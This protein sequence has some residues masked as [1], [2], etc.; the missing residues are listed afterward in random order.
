[1]QAIKKEMR[2]LQNQATAL[3]LGRT[4]GNEPM[5]SSFGLALEYPQ[6]ENV[7]FGDVMA[8]RVKRPIMGPDPQRLLRY[9]RIDQVQSA[10]E[11]EQVAQAAAK[12][13]ERRIDPGRNEFFSSKPAPVAVDYPEP[14]FY[15][16][17]RSTTV[18]ELKT[19]LFTSP[20][21]GVIAKFKALNPGLSQV[22]AG[23][24]IVLSDPENYRCTQEEAQLMA[25][26]SVV[27]EALADLSPEEADFMVRHRDEIESFITYGSTGTSI[28]AAM[29]ESNL[30]NVKGVLEAIED[31]HTRSFAKHGHLRSPE[32]FAER[33]K[34]FAQLDTHL[35][36]LT[37][38]TID[39]PDHPKQNAALGISSRGLVHRWSW[40]GGQGMSPGYATHIDKVTKA[41][42]Y[43]KYGGWIGTAVGGGVS[44]MKVQDVCQA[45]DAEACEKAKYT[46]TGGLIGGVTGGILAGG[47]LS[48]VGT[49]AICA[50]LFVP[51][52][53]IGTLACG[54]VVAGG[55]TFGT[56]YVL[57]MAGEKAGERIYE[58]N[59]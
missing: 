45:G 54:L 23:Q 41:S 14:G 55:V 30:N 22:K 38:I 42:K 50:A 37:K 26:A 46:E 52:A 39:Y 48:V 20:G 49:G 28:A 27:N 24:M 25:T 36:K 33:K 1:M 51:T 29:F 6:P 34:L 8:A 13:A 57:G 40:A 43:I 44:Y 21:S 10:Y 32:F 58:V 59:K 31:L 18:E 17:P 15:I 35:A 53:G 56:G 3:T 5:R 12:A 11:K 19:Q 16:V 9:L 4:P 2:S 47:A 7:T